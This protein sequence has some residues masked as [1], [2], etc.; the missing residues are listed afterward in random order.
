MR[1]RAAC[2][3]SECSIISYRTDHYCCTAVLLHEEAWSNIRMQP[4][5]ACIRNGWKP[6]VSEWSGGQETD[7]EVP[8]S[9]IDSLQ[10]RTEQLRR[11]SPCAQVRHHICAICNCPCIGSALQEGECYVLFL[12]YPVFEEAHVKHWELGA[13]ILN[14]TG[15]TM[16]VSIGKKQ[17]WRSY[18]RTKRENLYRTASAD[19]TRF[20]N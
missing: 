12:R 18:W 11:I 17:H 5:E 2:T 20:L 1:S 6:I 10:Q 8:S 13:L 9:L 16:F 3:F 15:N 14:D 4:Y 19:S 7:Q